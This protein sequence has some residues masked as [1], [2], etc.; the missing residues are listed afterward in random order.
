MDR[1]ELKEN[2]DELAR[3]IAE[4]EP[5]DSPEGG[6]SPELVRK[7]Q[8][9]KDKISESTGVGRAP[10]DVDKLKEEMHSVLRLKTVME[11]HQCIERYKEITDKSHADCY[12]DILPFLMELIITPALAMAG[13]EREM[14]INNSGKLRDACIAAVFSL[15]AEFIDNKETRLG[16]KAP[17]EIPDELSNWLKQQGRG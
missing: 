6:P 8:E 16:P 7:I 3:L 4:A 5:A 12:V 1:D 11:M 17:I 13:V 15:V 9:V 2:V 10:F 14:V